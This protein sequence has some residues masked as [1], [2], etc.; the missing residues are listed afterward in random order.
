M[1]KMLYVV[2][3]NY[4]LSPQEQRTISLVHLVII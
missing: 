1:D 2:E 4:C 3:V